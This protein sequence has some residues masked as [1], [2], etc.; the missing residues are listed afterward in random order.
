MAKYKKP[1]LIG[2]VVVK[3]PAYFLSSFAVSRITFEVECNDE[4]FS[5]KL[6]PILRLPK[7]KPHSHPIIPVTR[8]N[9]INE[10]QVRPLFS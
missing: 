9:V 2:A 6:L 8:A 7:K 1:P 3:R 4:V 10:I 5:K